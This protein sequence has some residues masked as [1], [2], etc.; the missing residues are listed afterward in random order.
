MEIKKSG[1]SFAVQLHSLIFASLRTAMATYDIQG[2]KGLLQNARK[3]PGV[4]AI[5]V[6]SPNGV[7]RLDGDKD[8]SRALVG[9]VDCQVC[10]GKTGDRDV[11]ERGQMKEAAFFVQWEEV[12]NLKGERSFQMVSH[13]LNQRD[14][15][16]E[17]HGNE[18]RVNGV[19]QMNV[20]LSGLDQSLAGIRKSGEERLATF[21][22]NVTVISIL[23]LLPV[24]V[25]VVIAT[26]SVT[27]RLEKFRVVA[28]RVSLGDSDV[29]QEEFPSSRDEVGELWDSFHRMAVS[30]K[31]FMTSKDNIDN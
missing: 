9:P 26:N 23:L 30:A 28:E 12:R 11:V 22:R 27:Q 16:W 13:V 5:R 4:E 25:I 17:C 29:T 6:Y 10:H 21:R 18:N 14:P 8:A 15:C 19:I 20:S 31:F 7:M 2:M 3:Q 24:L 1:Q